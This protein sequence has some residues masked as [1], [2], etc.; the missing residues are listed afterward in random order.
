M[1]NGYY[2]HKDRNACN[3]GTV[4]S[5]STKTSFSQPMCYSIN[6]NIDVINLVSSAR[7]INQQVPR[8]VEVQH[9]SSIKTS[10]D[11]FDDLDSI[12]SSVK[13]TNFNQNFSAAASLQSICN[14]ISIN[15]HYNNQ[16]FND[17][18]NDELS[19]LFNNKTKEL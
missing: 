9:T 3:T 7:S 6:I 8:T 5:I 13:Y 2:I 17:I 4:G 12:A 14:G 10:D 15:D 16:A 1:S 18:T 11:L 19:H